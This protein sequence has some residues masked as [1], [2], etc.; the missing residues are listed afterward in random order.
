MQ[1]TDTKTEL[2]ARVRKFAETAAPHEVAEFLL[3]LLAETPELAR[4]KWGI[5]FI[6][7]CKKDLKKSDPVSS[8]LDLELEKIKKRLDDH[9]E[10]REKVFKIIFSDKM[11]LPDWLNEISDATVAITYGPRND[12]DEL[13]RRMRHRENLISKAFNEGR[14]V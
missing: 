6:A 13:T 4:T 1:P 5:E 2:P 12:L 9:H 8:R 7:E 14:K 3:T 10:F 11:V